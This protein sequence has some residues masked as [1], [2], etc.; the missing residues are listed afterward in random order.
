ME[1]KRNYT[2]DFLRLLM[3]LLI[4]ALHCNPLAEYNALISYFPSQVLSR[5]GV[6]FFAA[7]AGYYFFQ[8]ESV[9]KYFSTLCKYFEKYTIWSVIF[10]GYGFI[11]NK[12]WGR[13]GNTRSCRNVSLYRILSS[14]VY[15]GNYIYSNIAVGFK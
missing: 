9:G 13:G 12:N 6:P 3:A 2:I 10:L 1:Q 5:I 4:V 7:V 15:A 14:L 8:N 11:A